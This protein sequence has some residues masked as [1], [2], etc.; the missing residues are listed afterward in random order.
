MKS[1]DLRKYA[2]FKLTEA[3]KKAIGEIQVR[4]WRFGLP[5]GIGRKKFFGLNQLEVLEV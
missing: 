3:N 4:C 1:G 2:K 5:K